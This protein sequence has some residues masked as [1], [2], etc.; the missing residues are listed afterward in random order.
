MTVILGALVAM[1][2][3]ADAM[4]V[5]FDVSIQP[6]V[7][8][9]YRTG[10]AHHDGRG[11]IRVTCHGE[12]TGIGAFVLRLGA[13]SSGSSLQRRMR[14]DATDSSLDY[15]LYLDASRRVVWG[16]GSQGSQ[17]I[18]GSFPA[19]RGATAREFMIYGRVPGAQR[20]RT[21]RY[22]DTLLVTIEF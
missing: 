4:C 20:V 12:T 1:P 19:S 3:P 13:G 9:T 22:S 16:D 17:S 18:E 6:I 11:S 10:L 21:G 2:G 15:N 14:A 5:R 7:F 8:G